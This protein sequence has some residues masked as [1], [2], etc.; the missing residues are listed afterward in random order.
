[1]LP[2]NAWPHI[3]RMTLKK[4]TELGFETLPHLPYSPDFSST[5]YNF[6]KHLGAFMPK[7]ILFKRRSR[8]CIQRFLGIKS[9]SFIIKA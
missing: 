9:L 5:D 3:A 4:I 8:N 1:M 7:N 2:N 6:F